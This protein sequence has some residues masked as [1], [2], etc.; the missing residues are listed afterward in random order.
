MGITDKMPL[1]KSDPG[2]YAAL[3][4]RKLLSAVFANIEQA[5]NGSLESELAS[6]LRKAASAMK[7][8]G[9]GK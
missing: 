8:F 2:L 5:R 9:E 4:N 1:R 3:L 7:E 6:G